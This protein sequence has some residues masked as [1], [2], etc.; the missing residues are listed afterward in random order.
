MAK[1]VE[2]CEERVIAEAS[3]VCLSLESFSTTMDFDVSS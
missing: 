2:N 1:N 3:F